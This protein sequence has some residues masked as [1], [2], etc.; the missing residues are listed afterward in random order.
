MFNIKKRIEKYFGFGCCPNCGINWLYVK[1]DNIE[2]I[3][4][5]ENSGV[6]IC[7]KCLSKPEKLNPDK[8]YNHLFNYR[9]IA[10]GPAGSTSWTL[11]DLKLIKES[12][13]KM[14][15]LKETRKQKLQKILKNS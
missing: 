7:K 13:I 4:Y 6:S 14:I 9:I 12:V 2:A 3:W 1:N 15:P 10:T 8:I 5:T 11:S